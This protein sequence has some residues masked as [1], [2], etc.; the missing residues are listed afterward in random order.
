MPPM[1]PFTKA[2]MLLCVA[3]FFLDQLLDQSLS[4][5]PWLALWPVS[6]GNFF[7]WQLL[8]YGFLHGSLSHLIFNMLGLWMFG[9]ELERLWGH[10]RYWHLLLASLFTAGLTQLLVTFLL[11]S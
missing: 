3:V 5:G 7:P 8:T 1:P 10:T 9:A 2:L 4:L 6:S 11:G